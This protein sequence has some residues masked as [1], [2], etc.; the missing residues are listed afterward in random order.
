MSRR[1][2]IFSRDEEMVNMISHALGILFGLIVLPFTIFNA[3]QAEKGSLSIMGVVIFAMGF[4]LLFSSSTLYHGYVDQRKKWMMKRLDHISIFIMIAGSYTPFILLFFWQKVGII[5]LTVMWILVFIGVIFKLYST[6]K[7]R[8]LSTFI[9]V[10]M[11]LAIFLVSDQF[12]PLLPGKVLYFI[13]LGGI[14]YLLGVIFYLWRQLK[15]HHAIWHVF[16][17]AGAISHW[18]AVHC[19]LL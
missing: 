13:I 18:W 1:A 2:N 3:V 16:V 4:L 15:Y 19:A 7:Y 17:L 10:M 14:F 5:L 12:F 9:Y 11:G 6:G 8:Y